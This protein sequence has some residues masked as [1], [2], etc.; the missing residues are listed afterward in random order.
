MKKNIKLINKK[1]KIIINMIDNSLLYIFEFSKKEPTEYQR[2][3]ST[4]YGL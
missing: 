4:I 3:K 1:N 2:F